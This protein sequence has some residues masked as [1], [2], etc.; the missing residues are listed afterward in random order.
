MLSDSLGL[1]SEVNQPRRLGDATRQTKEN[2]Y[3]CLTR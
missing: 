3:R 1:A 2:P